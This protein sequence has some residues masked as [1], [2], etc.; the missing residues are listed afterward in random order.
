MAFLGNLQ[1]P[2]ESEIVEKLGLEYFG[3]D[4]ERIENDIEWYSERRGEVV[5]VHVDEEGKTYI[6]FSSPDK[7]GQRFYLKEAGYQLTGP[8]KTFTEDEQKRWKDKAI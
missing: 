5:P 2:R 3:I 6:I 8:I 7:K 4:W 1:G